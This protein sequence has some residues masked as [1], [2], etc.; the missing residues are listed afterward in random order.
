[1]NLV[2]KSFIGWNSGYS[3]KRISTYVGI[4]SAILGCGH[5]DENISNQHFSQIKAVSKS[6]EKVLY[7]D[8]HDD[9][10][11][12]GKVDASVFNYFKKVDGKKAISL[13]FD[14]A[15]VDHAD[16]IKIIDFLKSRKIKTTIFIS[17]P[18][19]F[20]NYKM[21]S[22][23]GV[24]NLNKNNFAMIRRLIDDGHEFGNHTW[25]HPHNLKSGETVS[26]IDWTAELKDLEIGWNNIV[27]QI[28]RT[29]TPLNAKMKPFWRAPYGE[30][31]V[32]AL[33][34]AAKA[35]YPLHFG[36][37]SDSR[38]STGLPDCRVD[39]QN[40]SCL[41]P[42]KLTQ[43]VI[44][45]GAK[46]DWKLDGMVVLSHLQNPYNWT[47]SADGL[48]R[49]VDTYQAKGFTFRKIS[50]MFNRSLAPDVTFE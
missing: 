40:S 37:N 24:A 45:F 1:M 21:G 13:T 46:N 10:E 18:F 34:L 19:I 28:Y 41:N 11:H 47:G 49:L 43:Y 5:A 15:W 30:Y 16:G 12:T 20:K 23:G 39:P 35:G 14:C 44:N 42:N 36:W 4:L 22:S 27:K 25:T 38:D 32:R 8:T 50:E 9:Y 17:G 26:R 29:A 6:G 3:A 7:V 33:R 2:R 31:D 48:A